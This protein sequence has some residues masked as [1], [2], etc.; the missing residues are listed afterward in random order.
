MSVYFTSDLHIGHKNILKYR[1]RFNSM[2]EHDDFMVNK[3]LSLNKRDLLYVVGDF[4][5]D[6]AEYDSR[7]QQLQNAKC[8]I[9]FIPGNHDTLK[10][11]KEP[12]LECREALVS[13]K[14]IWI[15]HCPIHPQEIRSRVG[16]IHGHLHS[17]LVMREQQVM[18][19]QYTVTVPD[20]RY[21]NVNIEDNNYEFVKL[22]DIKKYFDYV[23]NHI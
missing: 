12:W 14:G 1:N 11:L 9:I 21:Y 16:N 4:I 23:K 18:E 6:H 10:L 3:I 2:V 13:Y 8:R 7:I 20:L 22:E 19:K 15:S 5:F 17:A